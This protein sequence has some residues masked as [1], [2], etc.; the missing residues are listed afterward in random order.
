MSDLDLP[1]NKEAEEALLGSVILG[2]G[3]LPDLLFITPDDFYI[4]AHAWIWDAIANLNMNRQAID[5][6]TVSNELQRIG[7]L[8][9]I[10]G[11]AYL[12]R[13][14]LAPSTSINAVDYAKIISDTALR[15]RYIRA[16]QDLATA[17]YNLKKDP[18]LVF[19]NLIASQIKRKIGNELSTWADLDGIIGP[20]AW[21]WRSWLP[22]GLLTILAGE[23]GCGK[24]ALALRLAA[25]FL[26]GDPWPDKQNYNGDPGAVLWCEAEAAQAVNLERAKAWGLPVDRIYTPLDPLVDIRLDLPEHKAALYN[27]AMLPEVR[28]GIIDSLRGANA[29]DENSSETMGLI[30]FIAEV[31]RDSG[32]PILLTHHLRK[33]SVFDSDSVELERLRGSSAIVQSARLVWA[34][35]VPDPTAKNWRRLQVV[36]SNLAKFPGPVGITIDEQGVKFGLAPEPPRVET[37]AD[38]AADLLQALLKDGPQPATVIQSEFEQAGISQKTMYRAKDKLRINPVRNKGGK[39]W[40]WALPAKEEGERYYDK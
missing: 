21:A 12:N 37:V 25:C 1:Q 28:F 34:L 19:E 13:L 7:K 26:R 2:P 23:S 18:D 16:A 27:K 6:I 11:P 31:A 15:R 20:V 36:K 24:S 35:D 9:E 40:S 30:K 4:R 33:R 5:F 3:C 22:M 17:A 29:G 10:G 39:G 8:D 14:I 32:K 38:K